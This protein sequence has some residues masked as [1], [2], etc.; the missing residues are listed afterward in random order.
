MFFGSSYNLNYKNTEQSVVVNNLPISRTDKNKCLVVQV[1]EKLSWD[2][3][4]DMICKKASAGFGAM[5]RIKP[6]V[7]IDT[8]EKVYNSLVQPYFEYCSP[9][10]VGQLL[11]ITER[12][13]TKI[14]ISCC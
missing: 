2:S 12:Q 10:W 6:F 13:A 3:H 4:I 5:R 14:S 1:D 8:L 9:L 11:K 7:R